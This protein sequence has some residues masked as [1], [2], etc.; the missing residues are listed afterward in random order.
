MANEQR[1][2]YMREYHKTWYQENKDRMDEVNKEWSK[3]HPEP[4]R[5][6]NRRLTQRHRQ[7]AI[8]VLGGV[9]IQCGCTDMGCLE[10][11]HI[12]PIGSSRRR[13]RNMFHLSIIRGERENLQV[14]CACCHAIK[15]FEERSVG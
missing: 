7:E 2:E 10:I 11:D 1:K 13:D 8:T 9:C 3:A 4:A 5:K 6:R 14:L 12:A 15:T